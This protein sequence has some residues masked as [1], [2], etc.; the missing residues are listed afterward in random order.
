MAGISTRICPLTI[1]RDHF[2]CLRL[3]L[4]LGA[5]VINTTTTIRGKLPQLQ[6]SL[7]MWIY[8]LFWAPLFYNLNFR[9]LIITPAHS[10]LQQPLINSEL[11]GFPDWQTLLYILTNT[12]TTYTA[13]SAGSSSH[14]KSSQ[15]KECVEEKSVSVC[16]H[17]AAHP[18]ILSQARRCDDFVTQKHSIIHL[19][20][21][22]H[23]KKTQF[24]ALGRG[25]PGK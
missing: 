22:K 3:S 13:D 14:V 25:V 8:V 15:H 6:W 24:Y 10:L 21:D 12:M 4:T 7:S 1:H 16:R 23:K 11:Y 9:A 20:A 17:T 19:L 2:D 18:S 5:F